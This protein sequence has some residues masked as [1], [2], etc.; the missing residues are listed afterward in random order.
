G[1]FIRLVVEQQQL[2]PH[3]GIKGVKASKL[4][5]AQG[6][7]YM[8]IDN[9]NRLFHHRLIP[10]AIWPGSSKSGSIVFAELIT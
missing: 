3:S 2:L 10:G 8:S 1:V 6:C 5:I 9:T 4:T 7:I